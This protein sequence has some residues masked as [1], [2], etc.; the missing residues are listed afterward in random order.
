MYVLDRMGMPW[1][2]REDLESWLY[3]LN[4][5]F[6]YYYN[7]D[8]VVAIHSALHKVFGDNPSDAILKKELEIST[9]LRKWGVE[10]RYTDALSKAAGSLIENPAP[11]SID[12][13]LLYLP[14]EVTVKSATVR[15]YAALENPDKI[16]AVVDGPYTE[17]QKQMLMAIYQNALPPGYPLEV[18][19][20]EM[21]EDFAVASDGY[22]LVLAKRCTTNRVQLWSEILK[23][24]P[25]TVLKSD[26]KSV[27]VT[28]QSVSKHEAIVLKSGEQDEVERFALGPVLIPNTPDSQGDEYNETE[29]RKACHWWM[30]NCG[31][32]AQR[33]T[34][35]GGRMLTDGEIVTLENYILP[36]DC[37]INGKAHKAGTWMV[38]SRFNDDEL[39]SQVE[40]G[41]MNTWSM[42][43][44]TAAIP[45]EEAPT[46][47]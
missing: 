26:G 20:S 6:D 38:G 40:E 27:E 10:H 19:P 4:E 25:E 45:I 32:F 35:Q 24:A 17:K 37:E 36:V 7:V 33:H 23:S 39:W 44:T 22:D 30:E 28:V 12:E 46:T 1:P 11:I 15:F 18:L 13:M 3:L 16:F 34:L 8:D 43:A 2:D 29:V 5:A 14:K 47:V 9:R 31:M 42:G 41:K 21:E